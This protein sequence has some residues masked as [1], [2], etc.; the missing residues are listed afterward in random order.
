MPTLQ[1]NIIFNIMQMNK[2]INCF[3]GKNEKHYRQKL[4]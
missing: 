4:P 3:G 2:K 1:N